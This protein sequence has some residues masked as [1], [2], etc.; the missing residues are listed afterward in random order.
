VDC[1]GGDERARAE[2]KGKGRVASHALLL[3]QGYVL[4]V[5][6]VSVSNYL[7]GPALFLRAYIAV[8]LRSTATPLVGIN[9]DTVFKY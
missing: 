7:Q 4:H 8:S 3:I 2:E 9:L 6:V 1:G 5:S